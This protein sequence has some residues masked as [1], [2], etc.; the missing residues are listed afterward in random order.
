LNFV[1]FIIGIIDKMYFCT[2]KFLMKTIIIAL[3][4][5][6]SLVACKQNANK[7]K[8]TVHGELKNAIDQKI[9]LEQLFFNEK[10]PEV[11]DTAEIKAGKFDVSAIGNEEGLYRL[12]FDKQEIGYI[13]IN[14][15]S[16]INFTADVKDISLQGPSFNTSANTS[17]KNFLVTVDGKQKGLTNLSAEIDS[18]KKDK[19][20]DSIVQAKTIQ[21]NTDI[22]GFKNFIIKSIDTEKDPVVAMFALGYTRGIDPVEL[23]T[24]VPNLAKRFP[25]HAGIAGII[26][27][28]NAMMVKKDAPAPATADPKPT[29]KIA[30]GN[31]APDFTMADTEGK[32]ISLSFFKGKYVLVDFWASWCGP[33]RGENPNV[34][35]NFNKYKTKNFTVLGVSLDEDKTKW[36]E[37]IKKDNLTWTHVTDLKGWSNAAAKIYGVESIPFNVLLDPTGKIIAMELRDEDLGKKLGEVVR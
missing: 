27:Q 15:K 17:F 4:V 34:V 23:K 31:I 5:V 14:D 32:S 26:A 11:L 24:I 30:V 22:A 20:K 28:Y 37:A 25:A 33:C 10:N 1:L 3:A 8:F 13:F 16:K 21:L 6:T 9:Y 18:L 12:R 19:K 2:N 29:G 7:G 36:L 35:A